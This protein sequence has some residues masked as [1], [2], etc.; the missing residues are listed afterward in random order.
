MTNN[1]SSRFINILK[2]VF[3]CNFVKH[4]WEWVSGIGNLH[5]QPMDDDYKCKR[6]FATKTEHHFENE[7]A[8]MECMS[9][10]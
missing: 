6:C 10:D 1:S 3:I 8:C 7:C 4:E 5:G 2:H 9:D